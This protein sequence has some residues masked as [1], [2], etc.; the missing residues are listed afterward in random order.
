M[1]KSKAAKSPFSKFLHVGVVVED[2]DKAIEYLS[3]LGFG[4]FEP[5]HPPRMTEPSI[6]RGKPFN[7]KL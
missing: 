6:F 1:E 2:M 5:G 4:P 7:A 3:S